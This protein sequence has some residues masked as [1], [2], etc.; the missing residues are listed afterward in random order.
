A[1][2][3]GRRG[4]TLRGDALPRALRLGADELSKRLVGRILTFQY[5]FGYLGMYRCRD[6]S[7]ARGGGDYETEPFQHWMLSSFRG[8]YTMGDGLRPLRFT[9]LLSRRAFG[10][11]RKSSVNGNFH[12]SDECRQQNIRGQSVDICP[13]SEGALD[14]IP[15]ECV[16][17]WRM[18]LALA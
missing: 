3:R 2:E 5:V 13:I 4:L 15:R 18:T 6:D 9:P 17:R 12:R 14:C 10:S 16:M 1:P 11:I 7:Q 8:A